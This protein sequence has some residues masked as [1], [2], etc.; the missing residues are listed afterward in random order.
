M[1]LFHQQKLL[2]LIEIVQIQDFH[3]FQTLHIISIT[4]PEEYLI[5]SLNLKSDF[6]SVSASN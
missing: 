5:C 1:I 4:E 2:Q 3:L 6:K